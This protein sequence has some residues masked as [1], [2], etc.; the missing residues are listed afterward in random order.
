MNYVKGISRKQVELS[1]LEDHIDEESEVRAIDA[2]IES[3][4]IKD[5]GFKEGNNENSGRSMYSPM[6]L[7]KLYVYGYFN[8]IRSS[9]KLEKQAKINLEVKWLLKGV[10]PKHSV[11]SDFRKEHIDC[12]DNLFKNLIN[13][14]NDFNLIGKELIA[15]DGTKIRADAA[16]SKYYTL[17]K[18]KF[19]EELTEEKLKEYL[20][21][22]E[23]NDCKE[24][25]KEISDRIKVLEE[26]KE[27]YN[28]LKEVLNDTSGISLTDPDAKRMKTGN[29]KGTIIGYNVQTAVDE[30]NK[31]II[32]YEV[33]NDAVDQGLL[34]DVAK[35]AKEKLGVDSIE[36]LADK[37]YF[38]SEDIIKCEENGIVPYVPK[39]KV[40]TPNID[41]GY[42]KEKFIYDKDNDMYICPAGKKLYMRSKSEDVKMKIYYNYE[43]CQNCPYRDK[44]TTSK[45]GRHIERNPK[46]EIV[47]NAIERFNANGAK[48]KKR[49]MIVEHPFG[50]LKRVMNFEYFLL[51]G[52]KLVSG[53]TGL[54]FFCYNMKRLINIKGTKEIVAS[55]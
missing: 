32:D 15:I 33:R 17:K 1:S 40:V 4:D 5:L 52:K 50:T 43:E 16:K 28:E 12:F 3:M 24:A 25:T 34:Y 41:S 51:R 19:M 11:I 27:L 2:L 49:Q 35:N 47:E 45:Y 6:D 54:A 20:K 38:K 30:K 8:G 53:E 9:R 37:A 39:Q 23:E 22:L 36:V 42:I 46:E 26:K 10:Q 44:C 7:I 21:A 55:I 48:Y 29:T 31:L 14:C 18:L 13:I